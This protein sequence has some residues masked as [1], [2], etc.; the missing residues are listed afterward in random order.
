MKKVLKFNIATSL[1]FS[2]T[3]MAAFAQVS[4][5]ATAGTILD[6][7][8]Y[9]KNYMYFKDADVNDY[10]VSGEISTN[11][12]SLPFN[13]SNAVGRATFLP[14][15]LNVPPTQLASTSE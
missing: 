13:E 7:V 11:K 8:D 2:M 9:S 10:I 3:T 4:L 6:D 5:N 1:V 15:K 14:S 12:F